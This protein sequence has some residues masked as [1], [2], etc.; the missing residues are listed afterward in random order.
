MLV[1]VLYTCSYRLGGALWT[2]E[3][4]GLKVLQHILCV[5]AVD[6]TTEVRVFALVALVV[7]KLEQSEFAQLVKVRVLGV[8]QSRV[9]VKLLKLCAFCGLLLNAFFNLH[10]LVKETLED[11]TVLAVDGFL[12]ARAIHEVKSDSRSDPLLFK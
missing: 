5:T 1:T 4:L 6:H 9:L 12:A 3:L 8:G 7:G 10:R 2:D 11:R